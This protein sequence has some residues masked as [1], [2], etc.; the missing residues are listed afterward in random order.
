LGRAQELV[1]AQ[2]LGR[3][4][5]QVTR[6]FDQALRYLTTSLM[7]KAGIKSARPSISKPAS[8]AQ[9]SCKAC[10]TSSNARRAFAAAAPSALL[11]L[12]QPLL[13][14]AALHCASNRPR[15]DAN[16]AIVRW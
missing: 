11:L 6:M 3:V 2:T 1:L 7:V 9:Y 13:L 8:A 14:L 10:C 16:V 12:L 15:L 4:M 5:M